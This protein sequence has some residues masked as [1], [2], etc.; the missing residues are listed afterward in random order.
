MDTQKYVYV[1]S[2]VP[3]ETQGK[4]RSLSLSVKRQRCKNC[5]HVFLLTKE[6]EK[7]AFCS[8]DCQTSFQIVHTMLDPLS[9]SFN[10]DFITNNIE[11]GQ[12]HSR[13]SPKSLSI[14]NESCYRICLVA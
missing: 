3:S 5:S 7:T 6:S 10:Q 13:E 8:L 14:G 12:N 2:K 9:R 4:N 1:T 11:D